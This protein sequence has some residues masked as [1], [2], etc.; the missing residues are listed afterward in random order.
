MSCTWPAHVLTF[1]VV[2][3]S[4]PRTSVFRHG[5]SDGFMILATDG[6][7][8]AHVMR[9]SLMTSTM[10]RFLARSLGTQMQAPT[11]SAVSISM[12]L[13]SKLYDA[14]CKMRL[15]FVMLPRVACARAHVR[16]EWCSITQPLGL[17]V[18]PDVKMT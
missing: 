16:N 10:L 12:T 5:T 3:A 14:P 4:P 1:C 15:L 11:L 18:L 6:V 13:T 17:P 8:K 9:R 7:R 2:R